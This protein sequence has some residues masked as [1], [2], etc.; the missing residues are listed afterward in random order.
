[1][2]QTLKDW[3][4]YIYSV[5]DKLD[6]FLTTVYTPTRDI[7]R[8]DFLKF[9]MYLCTSDCTVSD[10]QATFIKEYL[11]YNLSPNN[12]K[13]I[14]NQNQTYRIDFENNLPYSMKLFCLI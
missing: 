11:G 1:M 7:L 4:D 6:G 3:I 14:I 9:L 2:N 8:I 12:I 5:G 13:E 10:R